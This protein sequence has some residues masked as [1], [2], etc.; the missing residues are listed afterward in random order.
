MTFFRTEVVNEDEALRCINKVIE[1]DEK[2]LAYTLS[3]ALMI[4]AYLF[5]DFD[6]Q[7]S[8]KII[9][10]NNQKERKIYFYCLFIYCLLYDL[11]IFC[12]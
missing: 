11:S 1:I 12:A 6:N 2:D 9:L 4:R 3:K 8:K 10:Y 5:K 7:R